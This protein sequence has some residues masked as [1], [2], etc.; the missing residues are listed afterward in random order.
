M[1][2][3]AV[4][5]PVFLLLVL[6]LLIGG[7][8]IARYQEVAHLARLGARYASTHGAMYQREG[9]AEQTG[10]PAVASAGDLKSYLAG[11]AVLLDAER[12]QVSVSWTAPSGFT[13]A[14]V[15]TYV[16]TNPNLIPPGQTSIR[17]NVIVTVQYEWTPGYHLFGPVTLVSTSQM[18]M[19]Y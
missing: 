14:N 19:S 11:K 18:P 8:G 16:D 2:E 1:I 12:M 9:T 4:V 13:P 3:F 10:V 7:L 6:G 5:A 15:P 17:N